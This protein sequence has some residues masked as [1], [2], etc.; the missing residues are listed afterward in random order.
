MK[1]FGLVW[2]GVLCAAAAWGQSDAPYRESYFGLNGTKIF[3]IPEKVDTVVE[4][5][6]GYMRD[7]G[8]F[9]DR[10]D[11]WWHIIEPEKGVWSFDW[12]DK[13]V[14]TMEEAEIQLYPILC[15]GAAW[16]PDAEKNAPV[17]EAE[18]AD[19]AE[20][21][22]RV[23]GRYAGRMDTWSVWNEPNIASFWRPEPD[24]ALYTEMLKVTSA[25]AREV[26]PNVKLAGPVAAP[27][28]GFDR[29]FVERC[30]QLGALEHIDI[31]DHH[32]Y[33]QSAPE[34]RVPQEI[35]EIRALMRRYGAE[36]PIW[37][38]ETGVSSGAPGDADRYAR[39]AALVVRNHLVCLAEGVDRIY[40]FDLQNWYDDPESTWDSFL[41]LVEAD[42][43]P[44]PAFHAYS[45]LV[46]EVDYNE[47]VGWRPQTED[48][49]N[50]ALIYN[51]RRDE[52]TLA[53]WLKGQEEQRHVEVVCEPRDI[54]E[55]APEGGLTV[56][57]QPHRP[58]PGETTRTIEVS[59]DQQPRYVRGVDK[60][61]YLTDMGVGL[62]PRYTETALDST[63]PLKLAVPPE[64]GAGG[65]V[66]SSVE[67][68]AGIT[69]D[70]EAGVLRIA[71]DAAP[72]HHAIR[73]KVSLEG[74]TG[75]VKQ[76]REVQVV[77]DIHILPELTVSFRPYLESGALMAEARITNQSSRML[78]GPLT[79]TKSV[80]DE[81]ATLPGAVLPGV[82]PRTE[83]AVT[84]PLESA[85]LYALEAP[86]VLDASFEQ[87]K[88]KPFKI[89]TAPLRAE[90]PT[91]DGDAA[92]W[93][94]IP[95]AMVNEPEQLLR[96]GQPWTPEDA[97]AGVALWFTPDTLY[98]LAEVAD[99]DP[100]YN[101][102]P[103]N[104]IWKGDAFELYLGF[105]G[106]T[107]RTVL[108][109]RVEFQ[110]GIAPTFEDDLPLVFLFH[111]DV[112]I[113]EAKVAYRENETGYVLEAAIPLSTY[114]IKPEALTD[115]MLL[116]FDVALD[117]RDAG[118]IAPMDNM[119]G[120]ALMWNG[121]GMNWIDPSG[122]GIV[123][124]NDERKEE[125]E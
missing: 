39:Q 15:Y 62:E 28:D 96:S 80:G 68:P 3:H 49:P 9:L 61:T 59:V 120:C 35:R 91:L 70:Q 57:A 111:V 5:R 4:Q 31:F 93:A 56:H 42:G 33:I 63:V 32:Y 24:P 13:V 85:E 125:A 86:A 74:N 8:V 58:W 101:P 7:A 94:G 112:P 18:R 69:W 41:G 65:I 118:D 47:I 105:G 117:D 97:S 50:R 55:V 6:I 79:V 95:R 104:M 116:A 16:Y 107:K 52:Y 76:N 54:V 87:T 64:L 98:F 99:D 77:A 75:G 38:S 51:P 67:A 108:D 21:V 22:R 48:E 92:D 73:A 2:A 115:G 66:V 100:A 84:L 23:V 43:D 83:K 37:I 119:P 1:R 27:L 121:S 82:D 124:L 60:W 29:I 53:L 11:F 89:H 44:K 103:A 20:Y 90:G 114:E 34:D 46:K 26:N 78:A 71:Q 110:T 19:F 17:T 113:E 109:K 10:T 88:S 12:P 102:H 123:V 72:G 122:W 106:P 14:A 45:A 40:Y 25:A 30:F 81:T 36:K